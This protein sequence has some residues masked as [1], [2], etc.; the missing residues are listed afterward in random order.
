MKMKFLFTSFGQIE[1]PN[2]IYLPIRS[3]F[4]E[5]LAMNAHLRKLSRG[6]GATMTEVRQ[7]Y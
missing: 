7:Q 3:I 5:Q 2:P 4:S 1:N 6:V